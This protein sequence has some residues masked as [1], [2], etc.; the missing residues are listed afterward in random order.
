MS[1]NPFHLFFVLFPKAPR[2]K[3]IMRRTKIVCTLGPAVDDPETLAALVAAGMDVARLNF[4]H[5]TF[6]EHEARFHAV[7]EAAQRAGRTVA[8]LQDLCGPKIRVGTVAEGTRLRRDARFVLSDE[9]VIGSEESVYLPVPA[10]FA[11]VRPGYRL[12]LDDGNLE[13]V[14]LEN[15]GHEIVTRVVFGG[16]LGSKKGISAPE[17]HLDIPAVTAK[18]EADVRFGLELGVDFVALSFVQYAGDVRHLRRVMGEIGK[19]APII[20]KIE[21]PLAVQ[22]LD[23]ILDE[24]DGAMVAR[25]D[26]GVEMPVEEVPRIQKQIIR[27]CNRRGKPVITATQMLD[28]MIRNPRPTRA[29]VT[30]IA[31]AVLDGT[32]AVMLSGETAVGAYPVESVQTMARIA[33]R[34]EDEMHEAQGRSGGAAAHLPVGTPSLTDAIGEA[35]AG[36]AH[37]RHA[38]AI[39]CSTSTGG[40]ARI[41]SKFKPRCPILAATS[42][43]TAERQMALSW[44]VRPLRVRYPNGTDEMIENATAAAVATGHLKEGDLVVITAGTPV[45]TPGS[46]NLIKVHTIGQ[47]LTAPAGHSSEVTA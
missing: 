45:G 20:A 34:A 16:V 37:D 13:L 10:L 24:A 43:E 26:L 7:R 36:L 21:M 17:A 30:D 38:A 46:T 23:A 35:V 25:G 14:A 8:V 22:N 18:D 44:G 32:D 1:G 9:P 12:L 2:A 28:S 33:E 39:L 31:N 47:P 4:S 19:S 15:N 27:A 6:A 42:S 40:T 11:A 41:L 3:T 29:E 5:G